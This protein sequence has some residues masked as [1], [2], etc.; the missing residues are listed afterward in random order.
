MESYYSKFNAQASIPDGMA[1]LNEEDTAI[2][3][4]RRSKINALPP[5]TTAR[6]YVVLGKS[7]S[8][9]SKKKKGKD[10]KPATHMTPPLLLGSSL[11]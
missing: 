8:P 6:G 7:T 3:Q 10:G 9:R 1:G 2:A 4:E 11:A 5:I